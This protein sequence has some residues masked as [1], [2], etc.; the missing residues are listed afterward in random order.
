M[1]K[2]IEFGELKVNDL[3]RQHINDCIDSNWVSMGKK[4][5]L[6]EHKWK[7]LFGYVGAKAVASGTAADATACMV[8]YDFGAQPG[9]EIIIPALS[10]IA[11]ANAVRAAGFTPVFVDI[12]K[13]TM[14]IDEELIEEVITTKTRAVMSVNLMGRPAAL[15]VIQDICKQYK[16]FHISDNCEGYGSTYK[17]K[18]ALAYADMETSSHYIAH[19][20]VAGEAGMVS[21]GNKHI[22][23]IVDSIRSHGRQPGALYFDHVRYGLNFKT[24]DLHAALALGQMDDF[25]GIFTKRRNNVKFIREQLRGLEDKAWFTEEDDECVNCPHGFAITL[26]HADR[27]HDFEKF[28]DEA[29]IHWKRNFGSMADHRA[30]AYLGRKGD[31][32]N[33]TYVGNYG[34]HVG[35]HYYLSDEDLEYLAGK[36]KEFL[37]EKC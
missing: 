20:I 25:W 2:R 17:G 10:F 12:K 21:C 29:S 15:D 31:F 32:P 35:C 26:K 9:D 14:N 4:V 13:E 37:V 7:E 11:T 28:L 23:D 19:L 34:L 22:E 16:L 36:L 3:S 27:I 6:W 18:Y 8:L 5:A 24:S 33:A 1:K 30:F